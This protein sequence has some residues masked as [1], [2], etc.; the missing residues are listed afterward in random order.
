M[1]VLNT[2]QTL[3]Q[4]CDL[5]VLTAHHLWGLINELGDKENKYHQRSPDGLHNARHGQ[6]CTQTAWVEQ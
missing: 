3:D 4:R 6:V 5:P 1:P 2:A